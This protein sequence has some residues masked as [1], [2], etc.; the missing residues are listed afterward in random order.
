MV[1][2]RYPTGLT[3]S[4]LVSRGYM[5]IAIVFFPYSKGVPGVFFCFPIYR[6]GL[7]SVKHK[8]KESPLTNT[9]VFNR[10]CNCTNT[11]K[12]LTRATSDA[13]FS[14]GRVLTSSF[15]NHEPSW[16]TT[17]N[18]ML[19]VCFLPVLNKLDCCNRTVAGGN[20]TVWMRRI[21]S[22]TEQAIYR[23]RNC[24]IIGFP[25]TSW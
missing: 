25:I 14:I 19:C 4:W 1:R 2:T 23:F 11:R 22:S 8:R 7:V 3:C 10:D 6:P 17:G 16:V 12:C 21:W 5:Y 9:I 15:P 20:Q 24:A 18:T 13:H